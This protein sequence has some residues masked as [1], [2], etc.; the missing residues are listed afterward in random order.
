ML[1]RLDEPAKNW[2]FSLGDLKERE[3]WDDYMDAYEA[4]LAAT[5]TDDAPWYVVPADHKWFT[6]VL[7]S[8]LVVE[9]LESLNLDFPKVSEQHKRELAEAR[10]LLAK[11]EGK[12]R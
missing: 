2:K 12:G 3:R 8:D 4:A 11:E 10:K 6:R 7:I 9:A 5:S 1:A